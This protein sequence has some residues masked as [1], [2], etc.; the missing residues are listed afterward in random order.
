MENKLINKRG[1]ST[2][3]DLIQMY[4]A[5]STIGKIIGKAGKTGSK[6][7]KRR[8][9][10]T[11]TPKRGKNA[12]E[13]GTSESNTG[14]KPKKKPK[15]TTETAEPNTAPVTGTPTT[16]TRWQ[17]MKSTGK[18]VGIGVGIGV[19]GAYTF[20]SPGGGGESSDD[21]IIVDPFMEQYASAYNPYA[22]NPQAYNPYAQYPQSYV[23]QQQVVS[24]V[25]TPEQV[26]SD[27]S[28][29]ASQSNPYTG[30]ALDTILTDVLR[31]GG[32]RGMLGNSQ[33]LGYYKDIINNQ[34]YQNLQSMPQESKNKYLDLI[35]Y[36]SSKGVQTRQQL[37]DALKENSEYAGLM[38][39]YGI[40]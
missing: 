2:L 31:Y 4:A 10:K 40:S 5:G 18:K 24:Q 30:S 25:T 12:S 37:I 19:G 32:D 26:I 1:Y 27:N 3:Y 23:P 9:P 35:G 29:V 34:V 33:L 13:S 16:L 7:L 22:Y 38:E 15:T 36:L 6:T 17:R 21:Q 28:Q 20:G 11:H 14:N 39:Q 8:V